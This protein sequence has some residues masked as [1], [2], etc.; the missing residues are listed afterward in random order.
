MKRFAA[1]I[2]ALVLMTSAAFADVMVS[3]DAAVS[4]VRILRSHQEE[5]QGDQKIAV[6]YPVFECDDPELAAFLEEEVTEVIRTLGQGSGDA[7]V[8]GG[9]TASVEFEGLLSV[10]AS[11]RS[12]MDGEEVVSLFYAIVDLNGKRLLEISDLF[13]E[14]SA[15]VEEVI[16][17]AVY[18]KAEANNADLIDEIT[19]SGF[20]PMP[21]SYYLTRNV[22]RVMY[23]PGALTKQAALVD[24]SWDEL[25]LTW[26]ALL[27]GQQ[28]MLEEEETPEEI[29]I[30]G[31]ADGPTAIFIAE[32]AQDVPEEILALVTP[33]PVAAET[34]MPTVTPFPV[35]TLNPD[36]SLA[37]VVTPTPMPVA[38][39]DSIMV[40]VLTHGLWKPLGGE[41]DT[42]YQFTAD[43]KLLT[44]K[45]DSYTVKDGVLMSDVLA[46]TLDIGSDSAFTLYE[47]DGLSGYVLN[48]QGDRVAPEEF[49]TPTPSPVP[50]PTPSPTPVPTPTPTP[51]PT[52][53]PT[54]TPVPTP[55]L[56]PYEE[57]DLLAPRIVAL[58]NASF[59]KA[60]TLKVYSAPSEDSWTLE[61]AQVTTD[62]TVA[63]YGM[64]S[65]WV[66]V[67]YTIGNGS[68]GRFGYIDDKTVDRASVDQLSFCYLP[69]TLAYSANATDDPLRGQGTVMTLK[70]GDTVTL[71]AFMGDDWAYVET[72]KDGLPC[73]LFIP[74]KALKGS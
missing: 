20:V 55:T 38:G 17:T 8:R 71:L 12:M 47:E 32:N 25:P 64:D 9:Y 65:G 5:T 37:P 34:P 4:G 15:V 63:I 11:A 57:A 21:D 36:F 24:L 1:L 51:V 7:S 13:Q 30:I 54:P 53:T 3:Q 46:G 61:G 6:D 70:K 68:R 74:R 19:G 56:S 69:L 50:T 16:C 28:L 62:E 59:E 48:R 2:L 67:S 45:V 72:T 43:G 18:N 10:E 26:S 27:A 40:D 35:E 66:L 60:R 33:A 73:R 42:Y 14:P 39:N 29:G 22:L 31:G 44:I 41:G 52:P 58:E 23:A 49:V